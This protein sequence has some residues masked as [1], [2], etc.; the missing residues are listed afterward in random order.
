MAAEKSTTHSSASCEIHDATSSGLELDLPNGEGFG[1]LP[2]RVSI[3]EM[4]ERSR[5][6]RRWFPAG[7][8]RA[9]ERWQAKTAVEFHL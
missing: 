3:A 6:L 4:I 7:L 9:E 8:R 2:P 1:S 5:Q